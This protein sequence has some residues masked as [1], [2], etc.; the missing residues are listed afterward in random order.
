MA[1]VVG[2]L[3]LCCLA[4][5]GGAYI[6]SQ[7]EEGQDMFGLGPSLS[8]EEELVEL[9][10]EQA[11]AAQAAVAAQEELDAQAAA[12]AAAA[13]VLPCQGSWDANWTACSKP[14]GG[15]TKMKYWNTT[16]EPQNGGT[17]CPSQDYK[18]VPCNT[19]MCQ[20]DI[21]A[22][23]QAQAQAQAALD[24]NCLGSWDANW[25]AC[26]KTCGGGTQTKNWTTTTEP[27]NAGTACPSPTTKSQPCNTQACPVN[28]VGSWDANWGA[29]SQSCGGGTQT[30]NWTTT[31]P[32]SGGGTACPSP[33]T[34]S[35]PCNTQTCQIEKFPE[36]KETTST[37]MNGKRYT[38]GTKLSE[39]TIPM[40]ATGESLQVCK[41]ACFNNKDCKA[42]SR[43][44]L[45]T[46][47]IL[48]GGD[49]VTETAPMGW[50]GFKIERKYTDG[51]YADYTVA[52]N[53]N[54]PDWTS[55]TGKKL[56]GGTTLALVDEDSVEK[57]KDACF[58]DK[59]CVG[60]S[61]R[62]YGV[63][64]NKCQLRGGDPVLS[65]QTG[66]KTVKIKRNYAT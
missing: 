25:G 15:G 61:Y 3:M 20:A 14:C 39:V 36:W 13:A 5:S 60:F 18:E 49:V 52:E 32:S 26:S 62:Y 54:Y 48:R 23:A 28:C 16:Q 24:I 27:Q 4:S 7:S 1:A 33:T 19:Q 9:D 47:C 2:V 43:T 65:N 10:F 51:D 22:A 42:Y 57:C 66:H 30:K 41:D 8:G 44:T 31:T 34:K 63:G 38:G 50:K 35:Q 46:K 59:D 17:A 6:F 56:T 64:K 21:D 12:A 29:C 53:E 11:A 45:G 58:V 55:V 37:F 40:N